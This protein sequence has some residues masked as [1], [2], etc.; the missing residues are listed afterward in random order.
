MH[1]VPAESP[2]EAALA[3]AGG[4]VLNPRSVGFDT[5]GYLSTAA[6]SYSDVYSDR[7]GGAG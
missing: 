3:I 1:F 4:P 2:R 7:W 6:Y 5:S